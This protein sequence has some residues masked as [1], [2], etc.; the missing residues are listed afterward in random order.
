MSCSAGVS[1]TSQP[2]Q[3]GANFAFSWQKVA[4]DHGT[5]TINYQISNH[6]TFARS[7]SA[8]RRLYFAKRR[9]PTTKLKVNCAVLTRR[10]DYRESVLKAYAEVYTPAALKALEV[11]RCST[12]TGTS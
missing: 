3:T 4:S 11:L 10:L 1:G 2:A 5:N 8:G 12:V 6:G 7:I 9:T